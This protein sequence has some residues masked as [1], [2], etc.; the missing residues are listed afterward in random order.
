MKIIPTIIGA[1]VG[2]IIAIGIYEVIKRNDTNI[3]ESATQYE[4]CILEEY[5]HS[6]HACREANRGVHCVCNAMK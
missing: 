5:G 1:L 6:V 3:A 4:L 2:A